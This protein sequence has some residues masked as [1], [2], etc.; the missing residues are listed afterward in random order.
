MLIKTAEIRTKTKKIQCAIL[1]ILIILPL[2]SCGID[3]SQ[4]RRDH[5]RTFQKV[6][7]DKTV[8]IVNTETSL[9]LTD[10]IDIA[11]KNNLEARASEIQ[12]RIAG[13]DKDIAFSYFLPTVE[14]SGSYQTRDRQPMVK[15]G[16]DAAGQSMYRATQDR[17]IRQVAVDI[18]MPIFRPSTWFMYSV[19]ENAEEIAKIVKDYTRQ[20][21][22]LEITAQFFECLSVTESLTAVKSRIS[23]AQKILNESEAFSRQGLVEDWQVEEARLWLMSNQTDAGHLARSENIAKAE[24]L[25]LMGLSPLGQISLHD[26]KTVNM[27]EGKIEDLIADALLSNPQLYISDRDVQISR[28]K[29]KIAIAEFLPNIIGTGSGKYTSDSFQKYATSWLTSITGVMSV[30]NGFAGINQYRALREREKEACVKREEAC[31]AIML[32][33][34]RAYESVQDAEQ[35]VVL[36]RK[37]LEVLS[38]RLEVLEAKGREGFVSPSDR[39]QLISE[40]DRAIEILRNTEFGWRIAIAALIHAIGKNSPPDKGVASEK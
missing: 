19:R 15:A 30:F 18:Q 13:L 26:D 4:V 11:L 39:L 7:S 40:R 24:L 37:G 31:L 12:T 34:L 28:E 17:S 2:G 35:D 36:S 5:A 22:Q 6:I 21:I 3:G 16:T 20:R 10:C 14:V 32:Q 1:M 38:K 33:V 23:A 8:R 27:P 9:G 25:A 29:I